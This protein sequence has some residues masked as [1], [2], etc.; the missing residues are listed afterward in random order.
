[1]PEIDFDHVLYARAGWRKTLLVPLWTFQIAVLLCLMGIFAYRLAETFEHYEELDKL[2]EVP[3][4][5]VVW[6]ATNVGFNLIS[7]ILTIL[8]IARKATERLTPFFMVCT[9]VIRLTLSFA[10]LALD[11]VAHLHRMDGHYSTIGLSLDCGLLAATLTTFI[12]SLTT[13]RRLLKYEDYHLTA[14]TK[15]QGYV[16]GD[17]LEMGPGHHH[18]N[19]A[20]AAS[21]PGPVPRVTTDMYYSD[22][23]YPSQTQHLLQQAPTQPQTQHEPD[24]LSPT[25]ASL[26]SEIDR[27]ISNEF[28]W[29]SG[30]KGGS[31][32][33]SVGTA[34]MGRSG[35]V[36][37]ASGK[38]PVHQGIGMMAA[39]EGEL[40]RQRSWKTEVIAEDGDG[41][42]DGDD[43]GTGSRGRR[44]TDRQPEEDRLGLL[45]GS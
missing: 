3:M 30:S 8:E 17:S 28:G 45:S 26:K 27:A 5:E 9:H 42:G 43:N 41:D 10:V 33:V 34:A 19:R 6:E 23:V 22:S 14:G 11:I 44:Q 40:H 35:S 24:C 31:G 25:G 37:V 36:V 16:A 4:V 1:M 21:V 20:S 13:Y 7:L 12:Y 32:R 15:H 38:V 39:P 29:G 18:I 2:G